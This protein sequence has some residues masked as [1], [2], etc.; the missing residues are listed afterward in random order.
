MS[1]FQALPS[2]PGEI[3]DA[4]QEFCYLKE[5]FTTINFVTYRSLHRQDP[6]YLLE[7]HEESL[8]LKLGFSP[9]KGEFPSHRAVIMHR[10]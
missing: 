2:T 7:Q 8:G 1:V 6:C 3:H 9:L 10:H 5:V 4:C